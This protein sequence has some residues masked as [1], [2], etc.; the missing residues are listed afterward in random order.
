MKTYT[1]VVAMELPGTVLFGGETKQTNF[2][3][4]GIGLDG[5]AVIFSVILFGFCGGFFGPFSFYSHT[6][7]LWRFPG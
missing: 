6:H 4:T 7:G 3:V 1:N 5:A 2:S